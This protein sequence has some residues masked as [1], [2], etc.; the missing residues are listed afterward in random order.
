MREFIMIACDLHDKTML[1]KIARGREAADKV[2]VRNT[3]AGRRQLI[4][5]LHERS[6][7]AGDARVIFAYEASGQGFGLYDELTAAG[8]E[9]HVLA[10][11]KIARSTQHRQRKTDEAD[12][13]QILQLLRG[14]VLAGNLLPNVWIPDVQTRDDRE[15]VRARLDAAE[16]GGLIK[17]QIQGLL[18]RN[19]L[20]RPEHLK[21]AWTKKA[22]AWLRM[23][24]RDPAVGI[25]VRTTL[26]SLLRQWEF[27][28]AETERLDETLE[29]LAGAP[30]Y[31]KAL[32]ELVKLQ[33]VGLLTALVFLTEIG[34]L[35]RFANRRQI[36][37]YL[38]LVPR[39]YE[40][41]AA[42]DR[43]GHITRQGPSRVRRVLCQA[44]WSR[45]RQEGVDHAAYTRLVQRNPKHK[46]IAVVAA[47]RRLGVRMWHKAQVARR[48]ETPSG[49][50]RRPDTPAPAR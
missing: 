41:G 22:S 42:S 12:A 4:E 13:E 32:S 26:A 31:A 29:S 19:R 39:S 45:I 6:R 34:D 50:S 17:A 30:R 33:G 3:S 44:V 14:H 35:G 28:Q 21:G 18:K 24:T 7:A 1:L 25:G 43:K 46:K 47:M 15:L 48:E 23:L 10:P 20:T 11:T 27:L 40:S 36:S 38:G 8:F 9:C 37:A 49:V 2:T 16:K 5:Q